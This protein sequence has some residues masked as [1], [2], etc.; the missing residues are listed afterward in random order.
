MTKCVNLVVRVDH[1]LKTVFL[2]AYREG[3][4]SGVLAPIVI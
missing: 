3:G 2:T 4:C 1:E